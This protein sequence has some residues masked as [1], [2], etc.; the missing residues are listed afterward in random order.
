M[1]AGLNP[2]NACWFSQCAFWGSQNVILHENTHIWALTHA[3]IQTHRYTHRHTHTRTHTHIPR[4]N[5]L[6]EFFVTRLN[7]YCSC[8]GQDERNST[9]SWVRVLRNEETPRIHRHMSLH[10]SLGVKWPSTLALYTRRLFTPCLTI[11]SQLKWSDT[12]ISSIG[13]FA[14]SVTPAAA[15]GSLVPYP[16]SHP[17]CPTQEAGFT[18]ASSSTLPHGSP[19]PGSHRMHHPA[20]PTPEAAVTL[21][22]PSAVPT[23][24]RQCRGATTHSCVKQAS[25]ILHCQV[26]VRA[27]QTP[28]LLGN[29][30]ILQ[31]SGRNHGIPNSGERCIQVTSS[32]RRTKHGASKVNP[33]Q[34]FS[35]WRQRTANRIKKT[36]DVFTQHNLR[37]EMTSGA[38]ADC[39]NPSKRGLS[40]FRRISRVATQRSHT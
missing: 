7:E 22:V 39:S 16:G 20:C 24:T 13:V 3:H 35:S 8:S 34:S 23:L 18:P 21:D 1:R 32:H 4:K 37:D 11:S 25:M 31:G 14:N 15:E 19:R 38:E 30:C 9:S 27:R 12:L 17:P 28:V 29:G 36:Q 6:V 10:F 33:A 26:H 2:S 40:G 5:F